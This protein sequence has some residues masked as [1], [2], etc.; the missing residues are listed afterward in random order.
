MFADCTGDGSR[1]D[2]KEREEIGEGF[3]WKSLNRV[4]VTAV[5]NVVSGHDCIL[6][7]IGEESKKKME[8]WWWLKR[9]KNRAE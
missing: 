3:V 8:R 5:V 4:V 1:R 9:K 6:E 7:E 2:W